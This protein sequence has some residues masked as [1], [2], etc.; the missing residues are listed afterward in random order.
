MAP[1]LLV[2]EV[3]SNLSW[4][5]AWC[6]LARCQ[7]AVPTARPMQ[8]RRAERRGLNASIPHPT[9]RS[10]VNI[11]PIRLSTTRATVGIAAG[12]AIWVRAEFNVSALTVRCIDISYKPRL[13]NLPFYSHQP[14]NASFKRDLCLTSRTGQAICSRRSGRQGLYA[15]GNFPRRKRHSPGAGEAWQRLP[16]SR[17]WS[18]CWRGS[19]PGGLRCVR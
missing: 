11:K 6:K 17:H 5:S 10:I 7:I 1:R 18:R 14:P 16:S 19:S 4:A 8:N 15:P 3:L 9:F 13:H 2:E 12:L